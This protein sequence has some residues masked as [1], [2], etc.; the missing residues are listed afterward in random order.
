MFCCTKTVVTRSHYITVK[1]FDSLLL[2]LSNILHPNIWSTP[3]QTYKKY[4]V[5]VCNLCEVKKVALFVIKWTA[6]QDSPLLNVE[7]LSS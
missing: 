3:L 6:S 7:T 4:I 5:D 1:D 2:D